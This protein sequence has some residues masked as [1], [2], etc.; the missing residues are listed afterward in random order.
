MT[1]PPHRAA[2]PS[3]LGAP[4]LL[5]V[6]SRLADAPSA[7]PDAFLGRLARLTI[8]DW[9]RSWQRFEQCDLVAYVVARRSLADALPGSRTT[10]S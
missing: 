9:A 10:P 5:P 3:T 6:V 1:A 7:R 8:A 2:S 4:V